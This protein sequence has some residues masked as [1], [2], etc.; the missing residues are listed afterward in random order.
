[1]FE[2]FVILMIIYF[3]I[4]IVNSMAQNYLTRIK[5]EEKKKNKTRKSNGQS[6]G[7]N[8]RNGSKKSKKNL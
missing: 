5:G 2:K 4:S 1:M 8:N 6:L 7:D 3:V